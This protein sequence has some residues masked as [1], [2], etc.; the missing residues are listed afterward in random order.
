[1]RLE[2]CLL[3]L[4]CQKATFLATQ[5]AANAGVLVD[6]WA[7]QGFFNRD[8]DLRSIASQMFPVSSKERSD[9]FITW[10]RAVSNF[11]TFRN[12]SASFSLKGN[13]LFRVFRFDQASLR[14]LPLLKH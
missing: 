12:F 14:R 5:V 2:R 11:G 8:S 6:E 3:S 1:M 7:S 4:S 13:L 9:L 10:E